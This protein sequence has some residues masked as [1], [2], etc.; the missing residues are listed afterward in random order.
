MVPEVDSNLTLYLNSLVLES[1]EKEY[2]LKCSWS[3]N[4]KSLAIS[5]SSGNVF[6][7]ERDDSSVSFKTV[8]CAGDLSEWVWSLSW[9]VNGKMLFTGNAAGL[10]QCWNQHEKKDQN[11]Q[12]ISTEWKEV[13]IGFIKIELFSTSN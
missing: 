10:I 8:I 13:G 1:Y 3:Q 4:G 6:I 11:G 9:D 2:G 7:Y 12:I 5:H